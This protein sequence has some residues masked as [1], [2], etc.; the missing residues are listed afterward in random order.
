[1]PE[2]PADDAHVRVHAHQNDIADAAG[3]E[4]VPD[5]LARIAD[6]VL[7]VDLDR[8]VLVLPGAVV[9]RRRIVVAAAV[10]GVNGQRRFVGKLLASGSDVFRLIPRRGGRLSELAL[11]RTPVE[12]HAIAGGVDDEDAALPGL[13]DDIVHP[14]GDLGA[15]PRGALAP[16]IVPHVAND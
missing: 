1:Q 12:L 15:A 6:S 4:Q 7:V 5:L 14:R 8:L 9:L 11:R 13:L 10:A 3:F 16:V 2:G